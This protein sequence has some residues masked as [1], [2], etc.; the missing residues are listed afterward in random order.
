[1]LMK[2]Y[3]VA[4]IQFLAFA[5]AFAGTTKLPRFLPGYYSPAFDVGS[6]KLT[7]ISQT[8]VNG[9]DAAVYS[10]EDE[11]LALHVEHIKCDEP[12]CKAIFN[13]ILLHLNSIIDS[14]SGRFVDI[15]GSEAHIAAV[16]NEVNRRVFI[17]VLPASVQIWTYSTI[18]KVDYK[19]VNQYELI[20]NFVNRQ[21][22]EEALLAGN[23]E[24]G[25]WGTQIH[26]YATQLF[27]D[28][29]KAEGLGVLKNLL[30][31]TPYNYEAHVDF[32]KN[33]NDSAAAANSAKI[34]FK[35]AEGSE[36][37]EQAAKYLKKDIAN[38]DSIPLLDKKETGL[39]LILVPLPPC[40]PWLLE[41][42]ATTFQQITDIPVKIRR[43]KEYLKWAFPE[44]IPRERMI[45]SM[46]VRQKGE[47]IDF[48]GW[49]KDRYIKEMRNAIEK[50][51]A[52]SKYVV[53]D[54]INK[55][56]DEPGQYFVNTYLNRFREI[57][58]A[59]RSADNQ[60]MY[61]GIT[62]SNI[63]SGDNN[64]VFSFGTIGGESGAGILSYYM[65]LGKTL[66]EE[67]ESRQRLTERI[68]KELVPASLK[69]LD[70]PRSTDPS[71]PYSYSSGVSRLDQKTLK[72]SE[73]VK[74]ALK[75]IK[76]STNKSM[77]R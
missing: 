41:E 9:V 24:M 70:I 61:V 51:D 57:L 20:R 26:E 17:Y 65:M 45:Q 29:K 54:V 13:N 72:L 46:L 14:N 38:L 23:V 53:N 39:Q 44:R 27:K 69:Q 43:L 15:P 10:T 47:N 77:V 3:M 1:M 21:R 32:I 19:I 37:I 2:T 6:K 73:P 75:K 36:L 67:Y 52:L 71:C 12:R 59:Y 22:Y 35:N 64:Y 40:N 74:E 7:F 25:H 55:I 50:E 16:E 31:T 58:T 66:E 56:A 48:K 33:T 18:E 34:V 28:G 68:A 4:L 62:E 63:Y 30:V 42:A 11:T 76:G 5:Q 8:D 60:T 49:T